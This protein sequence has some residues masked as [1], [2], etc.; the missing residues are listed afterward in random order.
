MYIIRG[1]KKSEGDYN[2]KHYDNYLLF[3]TVSNAQ[4]TNV[5]GESVATIKVKTDVLKR[6]IPDSSKAVGLPVD[7]S[8]RVLNYNGKQSVIVEDIII[9]KGD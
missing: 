6:C 3:C 5:V 1:F 7:F 2:G 8:M 9:R 4:D